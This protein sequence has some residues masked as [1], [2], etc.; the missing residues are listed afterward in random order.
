MKVTPASGFLVLAVLLILGV[1]VLLVSKR[2]MTAD[3]DVVRE[4]DRTVMAEYIRLVGDEMFGEAWETCLT[5]SYREEV[6]REK[7]VAG[8]EKRRREAGPLGGAKLLR[9]SAHR[10]L[11]SKT[12]EYHLVYE[13][14]YPAGVQPQYA[15][16]ND[17]DGAFRIEGTYH[18]GA[19]E[20]LSFLLW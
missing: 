20:T 19:S 15:I 18:E 6:P 17:A 11:F 5:K 12:R 10:N 13:L 9:H 14:S 4:I 1:G 2:G 16:V 8:H 7:F 3:R